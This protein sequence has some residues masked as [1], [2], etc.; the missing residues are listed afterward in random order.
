MPAERGMAGEHRGWLPAVFLV[1]LLCFLPSLLQAGVIRAPLPKIS[2]TTRL[3]YPWNIFWRD[4]VM[5]GRLPFW[6]PYMFAGLPMV[7]EPQTQTFYPGHL[8]WLVL[9]PE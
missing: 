3:F 6:N 1:E 8:L 4:E 2:E 9:T 5:A 7:A